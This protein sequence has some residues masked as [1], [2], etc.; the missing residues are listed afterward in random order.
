APRSPSLPMLALFNLC[1][2]SSYALAGAV[3]GAVGSAGGYASSVV[4]VQTALYLFANVMLVLIGLHL[5]GISP[6]LARLEVIGGPVWRRIQPHAA[7]ILPA[8]TPLRALV[9]GSLWGWLPCGLVYGMLA[10]AVA[11][12]SIAGGALTMLA[13]GLGTVP[14]LMLAGMALV[15]LRGVIA[16]RGVRLVA[17]GLVLAFGVFGFARAAELGEAVRRGLLCL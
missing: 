16:R 2:I 1:R 13:F 3:A 17:G 7:R 12:G 11:S 8:D 5:A 10:T 9:A 4:G 6:L 15:R 14:N